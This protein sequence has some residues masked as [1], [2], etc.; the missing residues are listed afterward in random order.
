MRGRSA[1]DDWLQ[2]RPAKPDSPAYDQTHRNV[3]RAVQERVRLRA[4]AAPSP[5]ANPDL[6][7]VNA[8]ALRSVSAVALTLTRPP[9]AEKDTTSN[10]PSIPRA[11]GFDPVIRLDLALYLAANSPYRCLGDHGRPT[12]FS[13]CFRRSAN[14]NDKGRPRVSAVP[15]KKPDKIGAA[16]LYRWRKITP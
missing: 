3:G 12:L 16:M 15:D 8:A 7:I 10:R 4:Q 5:C 1:N 2:R 11:T 9:C 13:F 14:H 6:E